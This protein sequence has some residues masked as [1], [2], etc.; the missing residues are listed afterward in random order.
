MSYHSYYTHATIEGCCSCY[1]LQRCRSVNGQS[2]FNV[3]SYKIYLSKCFSSEAVVAVPLPSTVVCAAMRGV[4]DEYLGF[5][6]SGLMWVTG[7]TV[8]SHHSFYNL[9]SI[10][11]LIYYTVL[12]NVIQYYTILYTTIYTIDRVHLIF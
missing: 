1:P 2:P 4:C 6:L 8:F 5:W 9:N 7:Y 3:Y 11:L 10:E 12:C